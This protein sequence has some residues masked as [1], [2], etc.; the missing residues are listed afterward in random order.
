MREGVFVARKG[1]E[2]LAALI[3]MEGRKF[4]RRAHIS[5]SVSSLPT[6]AHGG[7]AARQALAVVE[8]VPRDI[9]GLSSS[10]RFVAARLCAMLD[11]RRRST[12]LAPPERGV[13][14]AVGIS[15]LTLRPEERTTS[16]AGTRLRASLSST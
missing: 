9:R 2:P 1:L 10:A 4:S 3:W 7:L 14:R 5:G 16:P 11:E 13:L 12:V 15:L 6:P 8:A